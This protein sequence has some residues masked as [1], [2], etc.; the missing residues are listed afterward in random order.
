MARPNTPPPE[1]F[2]LT[3]FEII[4]LCEYDDRKEL[5]G[6]IVYGDQSVPA[7]GWDPSVGEHGLVIP[8]GSQDCIMMHVASITGIQQAQHDLVLAGSYIALHEQLREKEQVVGVTFRALAG[9]AV[10]GAGFSHI[11]PY[12]STNEAYENRIRGGYG[13]MRLAGRRQFELAMVRMPTEQFITTYAAKRLGRSAA[14]LKRAI[15]G[16]HDDD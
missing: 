7:T 14:A 10:R 12:G 15:V 9:L 1:A 4:D 13:Q 16:L 11:R 8:Q 2:R 3:E 6:L 5:G